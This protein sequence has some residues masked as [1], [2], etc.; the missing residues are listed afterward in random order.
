MAQS[1]G[2]KELRVS[3]IAVAT[4]SVT[5][6]FTHASI[7]CVYWPLPRCRVPSILKYL[8]MVPAAINSTLGD[9]S[10]LWQ[11][12]GILGVTDRSRS[13]AIKYA[14]W[15]MAVEEAIIDNNPE[16]K[17]NKDQRGRGLPRRYLWDTLAEKSS[18][19]AIEHVIWSLPQPI[20]RAGTDL[21]TTNGPRYQG[22][23]R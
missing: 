7:I 22:F 21:H 18:S 2:V 11:H 20:A 16:A 19:K 6:N 3:C 14:Q 8:Q 1:H 12:A 5:A 23:S 13:L 10:G 4:S 17:P 15:P 9:R